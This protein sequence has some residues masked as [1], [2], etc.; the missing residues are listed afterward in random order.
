MT[1]KTF[2]EI[3]IQKNLEDWKILAENVRLTLPATIDQEAL[4]AAL[5]GTK[6]QLATQIGMAI[7]DHYGMA[8]AG[9]QYENLSGMTLITQV[10]G[11][12]VPVGEF[13]VVF[14]EALS[15]KG[16]ED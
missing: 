6:R 3:P 15:S 1:T 8:K 14:Q 12:R 4:D 11:V 2:K 10:Y 7:I 9:T 16:V 5:D 13:D